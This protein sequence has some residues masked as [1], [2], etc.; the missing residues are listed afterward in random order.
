MNNDFKK[1]LLIVLLICLLHLT[2]LNFILSIMVDDDDKQ[3]IDY[4]LELINQTDVKLMDENGET[5]Y[6]TTFD[7]I[8]YYIDQDNL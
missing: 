3:K 8:Q 1:G 2:L 7:S 5:L 6:I 4:Q